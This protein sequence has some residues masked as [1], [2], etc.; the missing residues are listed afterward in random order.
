M[1]SNLKTSIIGV[2]ILFSLMLIT[3]VYFTYQHNINVLKKE[4]LKEY[5]SV[6]IET[7][8]NHLEDLV[9]HVYRDINAERKNLKIKIEKELDIYTNIAK[10]VIDNLNNKNKIEETSQIINSINKGL[11]GNHIRIFIIDKKSKTFIVKSNFNIDEKTLLSGGNTRFLSK[12]IIY[13]PKGWIIGAVADYKKFENDLKRYVLNRLY[14]FRYGLKNEGY[15]F[16]ITIEKKNGKI[17]TIRT[18]NPN[19]PKS[20]IGK[21]IPLD[22]TD[23][24]GKQFHREMVRKC[25]T[26]GEG[27]EEYY[28]RI[29][30]TNKIAEKISFVKYYKPWHWMIGTGFYITVFENQLKKRDKV[31]KAIMV[32]RNEKFLLVLIL[33][34]GF[35]TALFVYVISLSIKETNKYIKRINEDNRFKQKLIYMIPNP[36]FFS[37]DKGNILECNEDFKELF[38]I[39]EIDRCS[40][41]KSDNLKELESKLK[42]ILDEAKAKKK[43]MP[44]D[45]D[46]EIELEVGEE[47]EKSIFELYISK[48]Q[49]KD[50]LSGFVC[51]L[52]D[53]TEKK[54][55]QERLYNASIKDELTG[56][57]NRRYLKNLF[58]SEHKKSK[59]KNYKIS[60]IMFDIDFFK[61]VNDTYGHDV[62][63]K[64]LK[65]AVEIAEKHIRK[66]DFLFRTG[67]EE[68]VIM[69][70][71]AD[72]DR[73]YR[74]A[75]EIREDIKQYT[76]EEGFSVTVSFGVTEVRE[77][78]DLETALKRAD[79]ALY[80]SK[81]GG[82][83]RTSVV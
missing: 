60:L 78:D 7:R 6:Y 64:V 77:N 29:P 39:E 18:L 11:C 32:K 48:L 35:I 22:I 5:L 40:S 13:K 80:E 46:V 19:K 3:I 28:F 9:N 15:F 43:E 52:I 49:Y 63:D 61:K 23:I 82:R 36:M 58:P 54:M 73:A 1:K 76:F 72:K 57:F 56:A 17:V 66:Y 79:E 51:I 62:G 27:F 31:L 16:V 4:I 68:F 65:K 45:I 75:E 44:E 8:K 24:K 83:D 14:H 81:R 33:S 69:L 74:I 67:G 71:G 70:A 10:N 25:L 59:D 53:I 34:F 12:Y 20:S 37:D 2:S 42:H 47:K 55:E 41:S 38:G 26:K 21:V 50:K 30:G